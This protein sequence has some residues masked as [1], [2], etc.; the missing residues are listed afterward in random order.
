[1]S[2]RQPYFLCAALLPC[3]VGY[4]RIGRELVRRSPQPSVPAYRD[5]ITT[6]AS[7]EFQEYADWLASLTEKLA[8]RADSE[9][10]DRMLAFFERSVRHEIAF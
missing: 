6:Y 10:G 9:T 7:S 5:W 3:A 1:M 4:A 8:S 2:H